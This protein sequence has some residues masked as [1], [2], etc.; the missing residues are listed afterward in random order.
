MSWNDKPRISLSD[1]QA[2]LASNREMLQKNSSPTKTPSKSYLRKQRKLKANAK[3]EDEAEAKIEVEANA[4][5]SKDTEITKIMKN[6]QSEKEFKP[7]IEEMRKEFM[8]ILSRFEKLE[9]KI[10]NIDKRVLALEAVDQKV[11]NI[12]QK[13]MALED[14][15]KK[16]EDIDQKIVALESFDKKVENIDQKIVALE[17]F[18]KKVE[19]IDKKIDAL[20]NFDKKVENID[21]EI[22]ALS[23]QNYEKKYILKKVPTELKK[24]ETKEDIEVTKNIVEEILNI[25]EM[26]LKSIEQVYRMYPNKNSKKPRQ[27]AENKSPNIFLKFASEQEIYSFS[28][29]LKRIKN[30]EKFKDLQFEK[31]V[32]FC[33][34]DQWNS[35]N[36]EAYRLRKDKNMKTKTVLRNNE[37]QLLAKLKNEDDF[38]KLDSWKKKQ[39]Q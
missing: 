13:I 25:A 21:Q 15:D 22:I 26:D 23:I 5:V 11:E 20:E 39:N 12:D 30:V 24:G 19:S 29:K 37:V 34:M 35:A 33:L 8:K 27:R 6:Q 16:V 36:F 32:P 7:S 14:F 4:E 17:D 38:V 31:C 2:R 28:E 3:S 9:E 18:D 1:M 10:E